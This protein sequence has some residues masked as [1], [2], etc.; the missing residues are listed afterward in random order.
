MHQCCRLWLLEFKHLQSCLI[1][2]LVLEVLFAFL[3]ERLP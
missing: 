1:I 3:L 2:S